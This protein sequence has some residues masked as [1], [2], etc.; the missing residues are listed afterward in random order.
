V[1]SA[2]Y[3]CTLHC[4]TLQHTAVR[5]APHCRIVTQLTHYQVHCRTLPRALHTLHMLNQLILCALPHTTEH[6]LPHALPH[7]AAHTA[8][9]CRTLPPA[10][11]H[12]AAQHCHARCHTLPSA[13]LHTASLSDCL[14]LLRALPYTIARTGCTLP[15]TTTGRTAT[16]CCTAAH[17]RTATHLLPHCRT[18]YTLSIAL[19]HTAARTARIARTLPCFLQYTATHYPHTVACTAAHCRAH[20]RTHPCAVALLRGQPHTTKRTYT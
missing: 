8:A 4:C 2:T 11:C 5:T 3:C 19:P 10:H 14:T 15:H 12:K 16:H 20:C 1:L 6:T 9:H 17:C 13:L 18:H 7:T